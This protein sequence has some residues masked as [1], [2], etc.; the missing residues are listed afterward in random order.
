[1]TPAETWV[2]EVARTTRPDRVV[3]CDGSQAENDRLVAEMLVLGRGSVAPD[4]AVRPRRPRDLVHPCLRWR[5]LRTPRELEP[6][7]KV[8]EAQKKRF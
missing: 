6:M 4:H 3:W 2:D 5:H 8:D 1:M 7:R